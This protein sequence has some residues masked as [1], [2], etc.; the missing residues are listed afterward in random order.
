MPSASVNTATAVKPGFLRSCRHGKR[1]IL[2]ELREVFRAAHVVVPLF[3]DGAAGR[4]DPVDVPEPPNRGLARLGRM[5]PLFDEL[6]RAHLDV[7]GE[8]RVDFVFDAGSPETR[9]EP[10]SELHA[11]SS[12][13]ETPVAKRAHCSVSAASCRRP[14]GV[15]R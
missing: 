14:F 7:K 5:H 6:A 4:V 15:I 10:L 2:R 9:A 3:A 11:G 13:F 8:L 12:T 1:D